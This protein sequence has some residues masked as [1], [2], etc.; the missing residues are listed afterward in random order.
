[1]TQ[2]HL[3]YRPIVLIVEDEP[4]QRIMAIDLM[5]DAGFD[6]EVA[7]DAAE[8]VR[9][10]ETRTD[11]RLVFADLDVPN[12]EDAMRLAAT[13]RDRWPP[14]HV[15]LTSGRYGQADMKLPV[16][17]TFFTKPYPHDEVV[18]EMRRMMAEVPLDGECATAS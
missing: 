13:I 17:T 4:L 15:I 14:I 10:L 3:S 2:P 12:G 18:R 9:I 1:M 7:R 11:I 6:I 8:A 5:E 16:D